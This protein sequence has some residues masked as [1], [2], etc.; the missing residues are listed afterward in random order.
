MC[1]R[2]LIYFFDFSRLTPFLSSERIDFGHQ[3]GW[4]EVV[5]STGGCGGHHGGPQDYSTGERATP[6]SLTNCQLFCP[7]LLF[8]SCF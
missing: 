1:V 3:E 7:F 8:L 4:E 6:Q 5:G 2:L